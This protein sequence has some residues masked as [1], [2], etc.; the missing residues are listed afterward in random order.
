MP[1]QQ[2]KAGI[3]LGVCDI[4]CSRKWGQKQSFSWCMDNN[5][6]GM[7]LVEVVP[8]ATITPNEGFVGFFWLWFEPFKD[9][10][11]ENESESSIWWCLDNS[12]TISILHHKVLCPHRKFDVDFCCYDLNHFGI[13]GQKMTTWILVIFLWYVHTCPYCSGYDLCSSIKQ[14]STS[15][16]L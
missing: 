12:L 9:N 10:G 16:L 11:L 13:R 8:L 1:Y 14:C 6:K 3:D 7:N 4:N 5:Y 15:I 2:R